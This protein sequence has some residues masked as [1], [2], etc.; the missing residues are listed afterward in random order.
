MEIILSCLVLSCILFLITSVIKKKYYV[1][2]SATISFS[3]VLPGKPIRSSNVCSFKPGTSS[4]A[5][6]SKPISGSKICS[7]KTFKLS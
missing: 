3:F 4:N 5:C 7:S 2:I 6:L 1:P